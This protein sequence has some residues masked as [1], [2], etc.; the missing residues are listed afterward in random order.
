MIT[1]RQLGNKGPEVGCLGYG[2]MVLEGF[3]GGVDE[4]EAIA[5]IQHALDLGMDLIDT[6]D[7]YGEGHNELLIAKAIKGRRDDVFVS[8][9]FGIVYDIKEA[10]TELP[11]GWGFSLKIN[12]APSYVKKSL[13]LSRS[14]L[15]VDVIDLW[16]A[17]YPDPS[18]PIEETVGA[19]AEC[20][21][22]G[23]VRYLGLC[24]V[25]A[26]EVRRANEVHPIAAV[27]YEYSLWRREVE[28]TLLPTL[29]ELGIA[30]VPWS[31]LGG[32]FLTGE[33][34]SLAE[35]DF[36]HNNPRYAGDNLDINRNRFEPLMQLAR[37][38]RITP[39]QLA[40]SWLLHQGE[41]IIPI[42]GTRKPERLD[43][44]AV[45]ANVHLDDETLAQID[46][47]TLAGLAE[48]ATLLKS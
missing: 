4:Q 25:T 16:Y 28:T 7:A 22:S 2:A 13:D 37:D 17:H 35:D 29:R 1:K 30:L 26:D 32:G 11:T 10:G 41:D 3:Y 23:D 19:M 24:N 42:P 34:S 9:K 45:S 44:N 48:G 39:A 36:R 15:E 12:G 27:Q 8:T 14:R 43:E 5:T 20:V 6:A 40:L 21:Q 33:V 46:E 31:P 38:F 18:I 47:I